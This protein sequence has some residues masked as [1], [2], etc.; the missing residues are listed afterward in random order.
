[1]VVFVVKRYAV[2]EAEKWR[3]AVR[4]TKIG[5]YAVRQRGGGVTLI[6]I[7]GGS[8]GG[9]EEPP[10]PIFDD[11]QKSVNN[12][13][14]EQKI[15]KLCPTDD[16]SASRIQLFFWCGAISFDLRPNVTPSPSPSHYSEILDPPLHMGVMRDIRG[17]C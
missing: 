8:R 5:R 13:K 9:V 11:Q 6:H 2:R 1:M 17:C 10:P 16:L 7:R 12:L 3:Y 14:S 15:R 4:K